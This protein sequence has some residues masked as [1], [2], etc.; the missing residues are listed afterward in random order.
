MTGLTFAIVLVAAMFHALWNFAAKKVAGNLSVLWLGLCVASVL[1]W[2]FALQQYR[3]EEIALAS[4]ACILATGAIH[5]AYFGLIAKAYQ[6]GDISMVYPVARGSGVAGTAVLASLWLRESLAPIG[7]AGI[8]IICL[9][10]A[11]LG[12]G[13]RRH[14][15]GF[16]AAYLYALAVGL[17]IA[18]YSVVDKLGVGMVHPVV[19]ISSMFTLT[20]LGLLPYVARYRRAE[21]RQACHRFKTYIGIIGIGSIGTYLMILFAY[22]LGPASY[23]VA[24]REFAVVVGAL[25]G[26]MFLGERLTF[27]KVAGMLAIVVGIVLVKTA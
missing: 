19:Y 12:A 10:T 1:S 20:T 24:V 4:L 17:T 6:S 11:L 9:G 15:T 22:R 23:I 7:V 18:L 14:R 21:C 5:T 2:P 3:P 16:T 25:L 27:G 13:Q 26:V 8:A